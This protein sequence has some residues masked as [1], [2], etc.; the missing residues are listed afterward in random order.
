MDSRVFELAL[1]WD[2]RRTKRRVAIAKA[3]AMA[4]AQHDKERDI[5]AGRAFH[6]LDSIRRSQNFVML[7]RNATSSV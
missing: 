2:I 3:W 1:I 4:R 5:R 7:G 6:E